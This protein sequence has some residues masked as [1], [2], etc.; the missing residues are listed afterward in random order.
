MKPPERKRENRENRKT[1]NHRCL[2]IFRKLSGYLDGE[3]SRG[4]C[5][6]IRRHL[7]G[8]TG[9]G[10]FFN[11]FRK[12]VELCREYP[13]RPLPKDIRDRMLR[14]IRRESEKRDSIPG[15]GR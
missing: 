12:T 11:T 9:C 7:D 15:T 14:R 5:E 10:A 4:G 6:E 1:G 8:C 3:I 2:R 13:D